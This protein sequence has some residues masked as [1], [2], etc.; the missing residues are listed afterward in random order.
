MNHGREQFYLGR[1]LLFLG[2]PLQ[3]A[4]LKTGIMDSP[5]PERIA[6]FKIPVLFY[7]FPP[8]FL[9]NLPVFS[10]NGIIIFC[11]PISFL[12][13]PRLPFPVVRT[14]EHITMRGTD[15]NSH[16]FRKRPVFRHHIKRINVHGGPDIISLQTQ[17]QFKYFLICS[18]TYGFFAHIVFYPC[19]QFFLIIDKNTPILYRGK[20]RLFI[21]RCKKQF[22]AHFH[23]HISPKIKRRYTKLLT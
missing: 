19:F 5:H 18:D 9:Q 12:F 10:R 8:V 6:H 2:L 3:S 14:H 21:I 15:Y 23:R 22:I 1:Y 7:A 11:V 17:Q 4:G 20:I 16:A 13:N